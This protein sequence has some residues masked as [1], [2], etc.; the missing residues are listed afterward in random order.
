[1]CISFFLHLK[2]GVNLLGVSDL[3]VKGSS[4]CVFLF[5]M[6]SGCILAGCWR[7]AL[8]KVVVGVYF[9]FF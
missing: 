8:K 9:F 4:W 3:H 7:F 6:K 2:W 5:F 1:M